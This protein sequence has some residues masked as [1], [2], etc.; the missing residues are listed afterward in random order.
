MKGGVGI[1][2]IQREI[3]SVGCGSAIS[4]AAAFC[5]RWVKSAPRQTGEGDGAP[6]G[7]AIVLCAPEEGSG[8]RL[9]ALHRGGFSVR[10]ALFVRPA[11]D[12]LPLRQR[13]PR[14]GT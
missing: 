9:A 1:R 13:A 8:A 14:T 2:L 4:L 11:Q 7:A 5:A 3:L 6:P 10:T 12:A